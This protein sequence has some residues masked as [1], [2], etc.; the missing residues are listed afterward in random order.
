M[1]ETLWD[2]VKYKYWEILPYDYRPS[3]LWYYTK[4]KLWKKYNQVTVKHLPPTW[5]DRDYLLH[6]VMFQVLE[7]FIEKECTSGSTDWYSKD[8]PLTVKVHG[9]EVHA[10]DEMTQLLKWYKTKFLGSYEK[11][12]DDLTDR[13][14]ASAPPHIEKEITINGETYIEW[15]DGEISEEQRKHYLFLMDL[16]TYTD[17]RIAEELESMLIRLVK[18][19][20]FMW[21]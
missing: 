17:Q 14:L 10:R 5:V 4:C 1:K 15:S 21:T 6:G 11:I 9:V 3:Q 13:F 16:S 8:C 19:R 12:R 7:D 18:V 2:K 20:P